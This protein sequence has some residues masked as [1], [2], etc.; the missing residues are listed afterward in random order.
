MSQPSTTV[1]QLVGSPAATLY[2]GASRFSNM[3][4][5]PNHLINAVWNLSA[6]DTR[7]SHGIELQ[8]D[9]RSQ[10][11]QSCRPLYALLQGCIVVS[12]KCGQYYFYW[13][14]PEI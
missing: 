3:R 8:Q 1:L 14:L 5:E 2:I 12:A 9:L 6:G 11:I 7:D 4:R 10:Q 13:S